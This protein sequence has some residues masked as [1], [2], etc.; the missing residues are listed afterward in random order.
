MGDKA[1]HLN[2]FCECVED[3]LGNTNRLGEMP[4]PVL[5]HLLLPGVI[6]VEITN[7]LLCGISI[8]QQSKYLC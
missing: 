1:A 6:P 3:L 2:I 4:L 8:Q 7:G 5:I